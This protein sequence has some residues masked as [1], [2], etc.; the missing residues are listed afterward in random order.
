MGSPYDGAD[1]HGA[2]YIYHGSAAGIRPTVS[3]IIYASTVSHQL[4]SFGSSLSA[5]TD[6][7]S[8]GYPGKISK[9]VYCNNCLAS[10]SLQTSSFY[11]GIF[12]GNNEE[13]IGTLNRS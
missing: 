9:S 10:G 2:I 8:N 7:D 12:R 1:G 4:A 3:Q 5:G 11:K 13:S 6:L